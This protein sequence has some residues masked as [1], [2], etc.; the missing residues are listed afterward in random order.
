MLKK[1]LLHLLDAFSVLLIVAAAAVL[2]TVL[3]TGSGK[4]PSL[5][6]YSAFR[7]MTGSMAPTIPTD[8]LIVVRQTDPAALEVGDVISFYSRDPSLDGAV[9]THRI[10]SITQE[11]GQL[12]FTTQGD[13]NNVADRYTVR[14]SEL[15]GK[16]VFVSPLLGRAVRLVS[17]PLIFVP[18][19]LL[20]LACLLI[21]NLIHT[22]RLASRLAREEEQAAV[23]EAVEELRRKR[24]AQ[25][26]AAP[27]E[28]KSG[29]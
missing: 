14:E 28:T 2:L 24:Q 16:V 20:P 17:N 5:F 27:A 23:R 10:L 19:V 29:T 25:S 8:S 15:V 7:V 13:A 9:N 26:A 12:T 11:D 21:G 18:V 22:V 3:F 4:A 1:F 6:G